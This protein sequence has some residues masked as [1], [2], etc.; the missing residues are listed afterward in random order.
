MFVIPVT[1]CC[2]WESIPTVT[3]G[4]PCE[5]LAIFST[6]L[7]AELE[8]QTELPSLLLP[9]QSGPLDE[10]SAWIETGGDSLTFSDSHLMRAQ[11][12]LRLA[13]TL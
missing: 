1:G 2:S 8:V 12:G 4:S 5:S 10:V 7:S 11:R 6:I 13:V 3:T 9:S